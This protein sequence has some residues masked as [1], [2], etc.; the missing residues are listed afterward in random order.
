MTLDFGKSLEYFSVVDGSAVLILLLVI[1]L[2]PSEIYSFDSNLSGQGT[3]TR[4]PQLPHSAS[5]R[6]QDMS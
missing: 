5:K 6:H 2:F 4:F 3:F 1:Y